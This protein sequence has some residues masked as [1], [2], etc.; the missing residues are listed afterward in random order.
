MIVDDHTVV[1]QGVRASLADQ[2]EF[3]ICAEAVSG[4]EAIELARQVAPEV[5]VLD[6]TL[7]DADGMQAILGVRK[8][9]PGAKIVVLSMH[10]NSE[11]A[12]MALRTGAHAY[13]LKSDATTELAAAIRNV[14]RGTSYISARF[15]G[16]MMAHFQGLEQRWPSQSLTSKETEVL[17]LVARGRKNREIA[18][19]MALSG[20]TVESYRHRLMHKLK[21]GSLSDLVRFALRNQL[22]DL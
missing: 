1:R 11:I 6:L 3:D 21:L 20:R 16:D 10:E 9:A 5:V 12:L 22:I 17:T 19:E 4:N 15:D 13:V 8:A 18:A 7:P 14:M 2:A